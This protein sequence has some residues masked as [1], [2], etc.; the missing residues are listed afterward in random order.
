MAKRRNSEG[1]GESKKGEEEEGSKT[2][3][4]VRKEEEREKNCTYRRI[5]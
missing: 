2:R 5:S 1:R 3:K 4:Q